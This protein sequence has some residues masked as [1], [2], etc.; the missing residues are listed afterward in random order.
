VTALVLLDTSALLALRDNETG[1]DRVAELLTASA[2]SPMPTALGCFMSRMEVLY[3]V[4]KDEGAVGPR[5]T[6][7]FA[8]PLG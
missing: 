3:R 6:A 7:R 8:D 4:W 5:A 1:A 2:L